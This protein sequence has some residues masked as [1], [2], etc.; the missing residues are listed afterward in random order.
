MNEVK[1]RRVQ[2]KERSVLHQNLIKICAKL[3]ACFFLSTFKLPR[4]RAFATE[5]KKKEQKCS[6]QTAKTVKLQTGV[7]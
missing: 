4:S 1:K 2:M 7:R 5:E 3:L 6:K